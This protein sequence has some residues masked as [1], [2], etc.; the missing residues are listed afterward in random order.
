MA[1]RPDLLEWYRWY[2]EA[3]LASAR[4]GVMSCEEEGAYRRL[5][6]H[7]WLH[8][9]LPSENSDL[10]RLARLSPQKMRR[11][12]RN[13]APCFDEVAPGRIAN[14]R[15]EVIRAEQVALIN[16]RRD[17]GRDGANSRWQRDGKAIGLPVR[18]Q[19]DGNGVKDWD[20]DR[21]IGSE[22]SGSASTDRSKPRARATEPDSS[23]LPPPESEDPTPPECRPDEDGP[24]MD[25]RA[26][27]M[28]LLRRVRLDRTGSPLL[29]ADARA[30]S[31]T[32]AELFA[33][34]QA[35][36]LPD[37]FEEFHADAHWSS[38]GW[39]VRAFVAQLSTF[40]ALAHKAAVLRKV[41]DARHAK[42]DAASAALDARPTP[43]AGIES[44]TWRSSL[45]HLHATLGGK[46]Y[47]DWIADLV[48]LAEDNASLTIWCPNALHAAW[49]RKHYAANI[50]GITGK[51]VRFVDAVTAEATT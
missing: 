15:L 6:D 1:R 43:P 35:H 23:D 2:P 45:G 46:A 19:C 41:R 17:A 27:V 34:G 40:L 13:L 18:P 24:L 25:P 14:A 42:L 39:P 5:L 10:A 29:D 3:A 30:L 12:W 47:R 21:K 8:G 7:Q 26:D 11:A 37:A 44:T 31:A 20:Q 38:K 33:A 28:R 36:L 22:G 51:S 16:A 9:S 32:V 50:A 4:I 48:P 49:V